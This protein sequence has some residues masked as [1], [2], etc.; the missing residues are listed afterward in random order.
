[1]RID[2]NLLEI[3][4]FI[5]DLKEKPNQFFSLIRF[6]VKKVSMQIPN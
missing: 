1:M 5:K 2:I 3:A 6:D 4:N